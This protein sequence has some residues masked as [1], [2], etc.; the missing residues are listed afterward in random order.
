[1]AFLHPKHVP[2]G[3]VIPCDAQN[4]E[5]CLV[6]DRNTMGSDLLRV[7]QPCLAPRVWSWHQ[8]ERR[9]SC[10]I[11]HRDGLR[12]A[13]VRTRIALATTRVP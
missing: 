7:A 12:T 8:R 13:E 9:W 10:H 3:T 1:M 6:L 2:S 4:V 11:T 5:G